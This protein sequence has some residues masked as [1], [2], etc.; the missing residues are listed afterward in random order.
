MNYNFWIKRNNRSQTT[1]PLSFFW[2]WWWTPGQKYDKVAWKG[3]GNWV[4]YHQGM[5]RSAFPPLKTSRITSATT[6]GEQV[7][8]RPLP[9]YWF[10]SYFNDCSKYMRLTC[11]R[12]SG[13][14]S[15]QGCID[16]I[17]TLHQMLKHRHIYFRAT[18]IVYLDIKA[19][20]DSSDRTTL[21]NW[22]M[23]KGYVWEAY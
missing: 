8:H 19:T 13:F 23:D 20:F 4:F 15:G 18:I 14:L 2:R 5:K 21:W 1:N 12:R 22:L 10:P 9:N 7:C 16:Y 3:F 11:E 6:I 17:F